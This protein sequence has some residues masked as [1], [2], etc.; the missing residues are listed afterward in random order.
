[1][2]HMQE[3]RTRSCV[4]LGP[5][6]NLQGTMKF[7]NLETGEVIKRRKMTV[8]PMPDSVIKKVEYW[9]D[10]DKQEARDS[11]AFRNRNNDRFGWDDDGDDEPLIEDNAREPAAPFPDIP[12]E[13]PGIL[14]EDH[15]TTP[16]VEPEPAVDNSE[17]LRI[18][19]A[20]AEADIG[21]NIIFDDAEDDR[22]GS[23]RIQNNAFQ[24]NNNAY[25]NNNYVYNVN[26]N[27][28]H[29]EE[30][31][32]EFNEAEVDDETPPPLHDG[33]GYES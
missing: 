18:R 11:L 26:N 21:P 19:R 6:G 12:A 24:Q 31:E 5:T 29:P 7:L 16:A 1:M 13:T 4:Y 32:V 2:N 15:I 9:A 8:L 3:E 27:V 30:G 25:Q 33:N 10:R 17:E 14:L 20:A 23:L 28:V 22:S